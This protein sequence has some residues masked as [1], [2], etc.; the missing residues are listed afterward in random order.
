MT[1]EPGELEEAGLMRK[2]V[3]EVYVEA[4]LGE[5]EMQAQIPLLATCA[6]WWR[7]HAGVQHA[8]RRPLVSKPT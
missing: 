5:A 6:S 4:R 3:D 2:V 8:S 7:I 1:R